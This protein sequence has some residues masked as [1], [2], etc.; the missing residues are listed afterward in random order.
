MTISRCCFSLAFS[1]VGPSLKLGVLLTVGFPSVSSRANDVGLSFHEF[2]RESG[3]EQIF[4]LAFR[5]AWPRSSRLHWHEVGVERPD[6]SDT[7]LMM[8]VTQVPQTIL[9]E[10]N[11][12][13]FL[14]VVSVG[15]WSD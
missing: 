6:E 15:A 14:C 10:A 4:D 9:E 2:Q 5:V 7:V 13:S 1:V 12:G 3:F 8:V 11:Y